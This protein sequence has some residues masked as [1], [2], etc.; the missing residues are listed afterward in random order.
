MFKVGQ[1]VV[2]VKDHSDKLFI[3]GQRFRVYGIKVEPCCGLKTID[4][5]IKSNHT[6]IECV[7]GAEVKNDNYFSLKLFRPLDETFA[8][9]VL[10]NIKEQIKEDELVLI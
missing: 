9:E 7:C 6:L 8:E 4:V 10:S 2:C 1:K 5:G 3:K